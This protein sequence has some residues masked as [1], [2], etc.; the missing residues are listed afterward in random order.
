MVL[1]ADSICLKSGVLSALSGVG[2]AT[3]TISQSTI[4]DPL[5]VARYD[6]F[7]CNAAMSLLSIPSMC[8]IPPFNAD[9]KWRSAMNKGDIAQIRK[10]LTSSYLTPLDGMRLLQSIQIFEQ[11]KLYDDAY[12]YATEL[13][14]FNPESFDAWRTML[15]VTKSTQDEKDNAMK[16]MQRLDP[17]NKELF[18]SKWQKY[19]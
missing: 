10:V 2:T 8:D 14:A 19:L 6:P 16:Q 5:D 18:T 12:I 7:A 11:N 3:T 1:H 4:S 9:A 13:V 15:T 17:K